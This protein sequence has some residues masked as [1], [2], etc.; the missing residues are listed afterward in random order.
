VVFASD[1]WNFVPNDGDTNKKIDVFLH[2]RPKD[3]Q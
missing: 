2:R 1:A 3:W